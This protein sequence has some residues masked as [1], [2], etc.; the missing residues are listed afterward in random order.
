MR[1][2][3]TPRAS[4]PQRAS[5]IETS[6]SSA[7]SQVAN[8]RWPMVA[9]SRRSERQTSGVGTWSRAVAIGGVQQGADDLVLAE[10]LRAGELEALVAFRSPPAPAPPRRSRSRPRPRPRSAGMWPAPPETGMAGAGRAFQQGQ[11]GVAGGVDDRGGEDGRFAD[12]PRTACSASALA[13]KKRAL[14]GWRCRARRR[15]RSAGP[16]A[17]GLTIRQ[18]AM[19]LSSSIGR[20]PGRGSWRRD[21]RRCRRREARCETRGSVRSPS[22]TARALAGAQAPGIAH[23]AAHRSSPRGALAARSPRGLS[24]RSA[25]HL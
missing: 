6:I 4:A 14:C 25:A 17:R 11:P 3:S 24:P 7:S 8:A 9:S 5:T 20:A 22:A 13:R 19:P 2:G 1:A 12:P 15:T 23:E 10:R 18:V 21:V 16:G